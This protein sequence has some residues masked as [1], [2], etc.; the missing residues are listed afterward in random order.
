MGRGIRLSHEELNLIDLL[1]LNT[2]SKDVFRNCLIIRMSYFRPYR[3]ATGL[4]YRDCRANSPRVS[5]A[6]TRRS[7]AGETAGK[8]E[9][10]CNGSA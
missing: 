4:L 3:R 7:Q 6:W 5:R 8:A 10:G 2:L 9:S 1:R